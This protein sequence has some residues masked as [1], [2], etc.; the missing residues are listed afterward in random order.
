M[1][2]ALAAGLLLLLAA[3][4]AEAP[5]PP[6]KPA[7][8]EVTGPKGEQAPPDM[9]RQERSVVILT[10]PSRIERRAGKASATLDNLRGQPAGVSLAG[11][12]SSGQAGANQ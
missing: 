7:L 8:W 3:C 4:K 9:T 6:A 1:I 10:V 5:A 11:P 2:R 12:L